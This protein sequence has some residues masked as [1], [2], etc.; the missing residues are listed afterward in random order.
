MHENNIA[1]IINQAPDIEC[2]QP[3]PLRRTLEDGEPFPIHTLGLALSDAAQAIH[4]K[5]QAP[6]AVCAQ[7]VLAAATLAVQ[8]HADIELPI[9]QTR[10]L[11]CF[12]MTIAASGE[13]KSSCD[14]EALA[15]VYLKESGLRED[16]EL[17]LFDWQNRKDAWD[18]ARSEILKR[19]KKGSSTS[20]VAAELTTLG[21]SPEPP[22]TPLLTC[23]EPTYEGICRYMMTGHPSIGVFSDE[24][25][26]FIGGYSMNDDNRLKTSGAFCN[27]WDGKAVKRVRAGD[28]TTI[29]SGRRLSMHLMVQPS[30]A[31]VLLSNK[32]Y[33]DQG[34]LSRFLFTAPESTI[35]TRFSQPV[36]STTLTKIEHYSKTISE[37]IDSEPPLKEGKT[38]EL[39]PRKI[40]FS[41]SAKTLW[42]EFADEV[43]RHMAVGGKWEQIRGFA[44]KIP[45]HAARLA[46]VLAL[47]NDVHTSTVKE[48]FLHA[49][50]MLA[51]YY[52]QEAKRLYDVGYVDPDILLAE[53]LLRW[54]QDSWQ[55]DLVSL[56]DIYQRSLNAI[57][58]KKTAI[59]IVK[60][61]EDHGWLVRVN[62]GGVVSGTRRK[63][64]WQ[65]CQSHS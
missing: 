50:I 49:G 61:L 47:V 14:A 30:V 20:G 16:Y 13:R 32:L 22:L 53:R 43:E 45:E 46:G 37:V 52:V 58:D 48:E 10:P 39:V 2:E 15:P 54:L 18:R 7:S 26:Q 9:G 35:G 23:P 40:V 27:L 55:K 1:H 29:L 17:S 56:P 19:Q 44:N 4:E 57:S 36:S 6:L 33:E 5:I 64:V 42:F 21:P 3:R 51:T 62:G 59:S 34:L 65:I 12:F 38:N 11:S 31:S 41:A 60:I 8:G 63:D 25:A 24:G 28:G